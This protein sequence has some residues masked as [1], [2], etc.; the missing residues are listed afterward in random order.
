MSVQAE[1]S[2][3]DTVQPQRGGLSW[4]SKRQDQAAQ[5]EAIQQPRFYVETS[6]VSDSPPV[7]RMRQAFEK[8]GALVWYELLQ[9]A[10]DYNDFSKGNPTISIVLK[11]GSR[12]P[13][14][15]LSSLTP[16]LIVDRV[17]ITNHM[18]NVRDGLKSRQKGLDPYEIANIDHG[19]G[20]GTLGEH[21]W[22]GTIAATFL[23]A[24]AHC[25]GI[26]YRSVMN[27]GT[28]YVAVGHMTTK[29]EKQTKPRFTI[30]VALNPEQ[31]CT[32]TTVTILNPDQKILSLLSKVNDEFL[33]ANRKYHGYA[34]SGKQEQ[35]DAVPN[36]FAMTGVAHTGQVATQFSES[37]LR[38]MF[39]D[40]NTFLKNGGDLDTLAVEILSPAILANPNQ[41][42]PPIYT[43]GLKVEGI[44]DNVLP[45]HFKG[46]KKGAVSN[47]YYRADRSTDSRSLDGNPKDLVCLV[48]SRCPNPEIHYT[49]LKASLADN[50]YEGD[51]DQDKFD[52]QLTPSA[53]EALMV[54][55][56]RLLTERHL[57]KDVITTSDT[58]V[59]NLLKQKQKKALLLYS[60]AYVR[61]LVTIGATQSTADMIQEEV[62]YHQTNESI[63]LDEDPSYAELEQNL[64]VWLARWGGR[65]TFA[66]D[67]AVILDLSEFKVSKLPRKLLE[68]G[69]KSID[70]ISQ[71]LAM[72]GDIFT[73][74]AEAFASK[75][76]VEFGFS[77]HEKAGSRT[78]SVHQADKEL[79]NHKTGLELRI[80]LL[81]K[82]RGQNTS[83]ALNRIKT[84][85]ANHTNKDGFIFYSQAKEL[86]KLHGRKAELMTRIRATMNGVSAEK[87][88]AKTTVIQSEKIKKNR[89]EKMSTPYNP[90]LGWSEAFLGA[91]EFWTKPIAIHRLPFGDIPP[92]IY[93]LTHNESE[94]QPANQ[95]SVH[96]EKGWK[97]F[98]HSIIYKE[99]ST[100]QP[101]LLPPGYEPSCYRAPKGKE[102]SFRKSSTG[103]EWFI[104]ANEP[105]KK[106][107]VYLKKLPKNHPQESVAESSLE[108]N[109]Q[110]E[111][112]RTEWRNIFDMISITSK[113]T[114]AQKFAIIAKTIK[115]GYNFNAS[116]TVNYKAEG[117]GLDHQRIVNEL[118]GTCGH[119]AEAIVSLCR[120]AHIPCDSQSCYLAMLGR[121]A[122]LNGHAVVKVY[123]DGGWKLY[124][125][126]AGR[127]LDGKK[128]SKIKPEFKKLIKALPKGKTDLVTL[129]KFTIP[130]TPAIMAGVL[131]TEALLLSIPTELPAQYQ[132]QI[133]PVQ[134]A[135]HETSKQLA[136]TVDLTELFHQVLQQPAAIP[137]F[138]GVLVAAGAFTL[139]STISKH[140]EN[141]K[142]EALLTEVQDYLAAQDKV[143]ENADESKLYAQ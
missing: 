120:L 143:L 15:K 92:T 8:N 135:I 90:E 68:L 45:W 78:A 133:A 1:I 80:L 123:L 46:F 100:A 14:S 22:G 104:E 50:C 77:V 66:D 107:V 19:G 113:L 76:S 98:Q 99:V 140:R 129:L 9:N 37:D 62:E 122:D 117:G 101:L 109:I 31:P 106:V 93:L 61:A 138:I 81:S 89:A 60:P 118:T 30:D 141:A 97:P 64:L 111:G 121:A 115:R 52:K 67:G 125:P 59:V 137:T 74:E 24:D 54:A 112:L 13:L 132:S 131:G 21:G 108:P 17:E 48:L 105:V 35:I 130:F 51:I 73:I 25:Q 56:Q 65:A 4:F 116:D 10:F 95:S 41:K 139:G 2:L 126:Q 63:S 134:Q 103:N 47:S 32:E 36:Q 119:M 142:M 39:Y 87:R 70:V 83:E 86:Q 16:S 12:I 7:E 124:E 6:F 69:G 55:Y 102:V 42:P 53:R 114:D 127:F 71:L 23:T 88:E 11:D 49:V 110:Y 26:E 94:A 38:E 58:S 57:P 34:F 5:P 20:K 84:T 96:L 128:L 3:L 40:K 85:L 28:P 72:Y 91:V 27:D 136:G 75:S 43:G 29:S 82:K 33:Y 44:D 18:L 79:I